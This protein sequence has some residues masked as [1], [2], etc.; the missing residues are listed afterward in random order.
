MSAPFYFATGVL[1][2]LIASGPQTINAT[3]Y[4]LMKAKQDGFNVS[5]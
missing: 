2:K 4:A 5:L 3:V 1:Q